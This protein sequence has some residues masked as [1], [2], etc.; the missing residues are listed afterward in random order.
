MYLG[1][2]FQYDPWREM[3]RLQDEVNRMFDL[4]G[5]GSG[6]VRPALNIWTNPDTALITAELPG[7]NPDDIDISI[8]NDQLKL[9]GSRP[10]PDKKDGDQLHRQERHFGQFMRT[11][12]LPFKVDS[13]RVQA[14]FSNGVLSIS[15]PRAEEDKPKKIAI[16]NNN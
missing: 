1:S 15:L 6:H 4:T 10:R 7:Y 9:T 8:V 3:S 14:E 16:K 13:K 12:R 5:F 2:Y 11:V